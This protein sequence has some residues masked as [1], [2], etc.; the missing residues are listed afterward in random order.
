MKKLYIKHYNIKSLCLKKN[1]LNILFFKSCTTNSF[2][3]EVKDRNYS[4]IIRE[5]TNQ[6]LLEMLQI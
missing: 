6:M 5:I 4:N 3:K 1:W 2:F